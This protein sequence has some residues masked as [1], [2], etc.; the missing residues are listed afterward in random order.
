MLI[1]V[2]RRLVN[3]ALVVAAASIL[4]FLIVSLAGDPLASL[5][6]S[7]GTSAKTVE[8]YREML[9]LNDPIIVRYFNW[10][11]NLLQG[12]LGTSYS[13]QEVAPMIF[14]GLI[15]TLKL[16][17]PSVLFGFLAAVVIGVFGALKQNSAI[18]H[19]ISAITYVIY[20]VPIFVLG[21]V[22][23][24]F[25]AVP[26]NGLFGSTV[27][28]T[29]GDR[30]PGVAPSFFDQFRY[31][32]LP[33]FALAVYNMAPWSR[34]QRAAMIEVMT[35]E[36]IKVARAKGL[37]RRKVVIVH[38]LRN[39]LIPVVSIAG[40]DFAVI[41]GGAIVTE[42]VFG[43]QGMGRVLVDALTG[44]VSP[45]VYVVQGWILV[46]AVLVVL[47]NIVVDILYRVLDPRVAL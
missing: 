1:Y 23:K 16:V 13:G 11:G 4:A 7:P 36:Y 33:V 8:H 12:D 19:F 39:A 35:S 38:G 3:G 22:L 9:H 17:I 18:D 47:I 25:V 6:S 27:I 5:M 29:M 45:D 44:P 21:V 31:A 43:W 34:Y 10:V 24:D 15:I 42:T 46:V 20:A 26:L 40:T 30:T 32:I 41:I 37:S 2:L 14:S 28:P